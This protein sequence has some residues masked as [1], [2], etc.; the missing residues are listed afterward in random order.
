MKE[1]STCCAQV[2][3]EHL[4]LP[5][6]HGGASL[7]APSQRDDC[8]QAQAPP[9]TGKQ[10]GGVFGGDPLQTSDSAQLIADCR[11]P[12][13][14]SFRCVKVASNRISRETN[15]LVSVSQSPKERYLKRTVSLGIDM[16]RLVD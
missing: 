8:P 14:R 15:L 3:A 1:L 16:P 5:V 7:L 12:R 4:C 9:A 13:V 10:H 11:V 2:L 6:R